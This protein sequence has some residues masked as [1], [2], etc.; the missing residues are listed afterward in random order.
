MKIVECSLE[1]HGEAILALFNYAIEH[2]TALYEYQ[3]RD[4]AFMQQWFAKKACASYPVIG[5][6]DEETG[7]LMGFASFGAFRAEAAYAST[8]EHSV[9]VDRAFH[10]RGVAKRLMQALIQRARQADYHLMVGAIDASNSASIALHDH[11]AFRHAG[12]LSQAAYKFDRWLDLA[13]YE[14]ILD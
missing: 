4:Q 10:R 9:Y 11:F 8:I 6:E 7:K 14:L 12:T 5:I 2:T 1:Q 3:P 13:L